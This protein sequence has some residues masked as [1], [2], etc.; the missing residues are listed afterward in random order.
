MK[1]KINTV[2]LIVVAIIGILIIGI[3]M[4]S[5]RTQP[6]IEG[7]ER[8]AD[9]GNKH[10]ASLDTEHDTYNSNPPTSGPHLGSIAPWGVSTEIIPDELQV[11]NLEDGGVIVQYNP[12]IL[13]QEEWSALEGAVTSLGRTHI[14]V[15]PRYN[16]PQAIAV[17]AWNK[18]LILD[19]VDAEKIQQFIRAYEGIDHH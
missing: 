2:P 11:H 18:L 5:T 15:A 12:D 19:T 9:M 3:W 4:T 17:T 14:I 13:A 6:E 16:M 10:I 8:I 1:K 7:V